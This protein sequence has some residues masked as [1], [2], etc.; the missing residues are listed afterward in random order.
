MKSGSR[1]CHGIGY[2]FRV[3]TPSFF[4]EAVSAHEFWFLIFSRFTGTAI[5]QR[6][7]TRCCE[8]FTAV[9]FIVCEIFRSQSS[10]IQH[11][12]IAQLTCLFHDVMWKNMCIF[13]RTLHSSSFAWSE[14][15]ASLKKVD[16]KMDPKISTVC[17]SES[18]RNHFAL[19]ISFK[20][21]F[22]AQSSVKRSP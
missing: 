4:Q 10:S 16:M 21:R 12:Y 22:D 14:L 3:R 7:N 5:N 15:A 17:F 8:V 1:E 6:C 11:A 13:G 9:S 20:H 2:R 18:V 19:Y